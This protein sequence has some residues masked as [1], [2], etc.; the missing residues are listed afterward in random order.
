[1]PKGTGANYTFASAPRKYQSA[2]N[3]RTAYIAS[4]P[5]IQYRQQIAE[6]NRNIKI[7][8]VRCNS[9]IFH[10]RDQNQSCSGGKNSSY[11]ITI[12]SNNMYYTPCNKS[13]HHIRGSIRLLDHINITTTAVIFIRKYNVKIME[14]N[15]VMY[16]AELKSGHNPMQQQLNP[17]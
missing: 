14:S 1:M 9:T 3:M 17:A 10:Q 7:C 4:V 5:T 2:A 15:I 8:L 12:V 13:I 16:R 11:T 6:Q